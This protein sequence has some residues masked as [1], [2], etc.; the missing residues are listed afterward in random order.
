MIQEGAN[1][2]IRNKKGEAVIQLCPNAYI[3]TLTQFKGVKG[4][5]E[6]R[7]MN[8]IVVTLGISYFTCQ[9]PYSYTG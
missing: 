4:Y 8:V 2:E 3:P 5:V 7:G 9:Y 1:V 6:I